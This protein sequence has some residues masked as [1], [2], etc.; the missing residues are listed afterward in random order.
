MINCCCWRLHRQYFYFYTVTWKYLFGD[1]LP[2]EKKRA[3]QSEGSRWM[4]IYRVCVCGSTYKTLIQKVLKYKNSYTTIKQTCIFDEKCKS[5]ANTHNNQPDRELVKG[6][7]RALMASDIKVLH[8]E[9]FVLIG[10]S[11][12]K[13]FNIFCIDIFTFKYVLLRTNAINYPSH[14]Q[15]YNSRPLNHKST[16]QTTRSGS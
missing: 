6:T 14:V 1:K 13:L 5:F 8:Y 2:R 15:D 4:K 11:V 7:G 9:S 16:L 10:L 12:Q 3:S